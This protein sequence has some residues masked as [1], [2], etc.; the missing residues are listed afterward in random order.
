M[1]SYVDWLKWFKIGGLLLFICW[2][3]DNII[4]LILDRIVFFLMLNLREVIWNND[5]ELFFL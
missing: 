5:K 3:I 4:L 2:S 1:L